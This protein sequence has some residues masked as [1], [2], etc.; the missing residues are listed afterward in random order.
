VI[1]LESNDNAFFTVESDD[2]NLQNNDYSRNLLSLSIS[3]KKGRMPQGTLSFNDPQDLFS[4]ILRTGARLKISWGYKKGVVTPESLLTQRLNFDEITGDIQRRGMEVQVNSPSGG[5]AQN[6]QKTYN[7]NFF[8]LGMRGDDSARTWTEGTKA[9]VIATIFDELGILPTNRIIDFTIGT[10]AL[11]YNQGVRQNESN[12]MFLS[13]L[14]LEWRTLFHIGYNQ[15]GQMAGIFVDQNK[16]GD[17]RYNQ[18]FLSATG[19]SHVLGYKGE[20]SN[21]ISYSWDSA[22]SQS[23][24]GDNVKVE[25][26]D[27]KITFRRFVAE[28]QKTITYR[29]N[30]Q[31]IKEV[32]ENSESIQDSLRITKELLSVQDFEQVK[33]FFDPVE[34][35]TA[36]F[37][38]GYTIKAKLLGNPLMAPPNKIKISNGFPDVLDNSGAFWYIQTAKHTISRSGYFT[39]LEII[40]VFT[41][42]PVGLPVL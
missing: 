2:V 39:D 3:E 10:D 19:T 34:S 42:S 7:C 21:V 1:G 38:Y 29:L 24:V 18:L 4:R 41:L 33:H 26:V 11:N 30:Q 31:R 14:A 25:V 8:A 23:G 36:P 27:G 28:Q 22:E 6:G 13:R 9:D 37:G 16:I 40:D 5:G 12:F 15:A 32:Y 35:S 17:P 20:L